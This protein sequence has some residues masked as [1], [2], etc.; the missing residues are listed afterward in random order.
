MT[1]EMR[2]DK[3][4]FLMGTYPFPYLLISYQEKKLQTIM[5][6][7]KYQKVFGKNLEIKELLIHQLQNQDSQHLAL[8]LLTMELDLLLSL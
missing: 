7:I 8:E 4:I 2:R 6:H 3:N 1:D 5:G